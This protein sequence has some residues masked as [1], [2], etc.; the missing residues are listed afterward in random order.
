MR[1]SERGVALIKR[2]EGIRDGDP[3]TANLDP[4]LCPAG[5]ATIGWGHVIVDPETGEQL[6]GEDGLAR[7]RLLFPDGITV[8]QAEALLLH[9]IE[10][11]EPGLESLLQ[12]EPTQ[13]EWDAMMSFAFNVGLDID[14][15][16]IPE[17]LGDSTLLKLFNAGDRLGAADQFLAWNKARVNGVL[18]ELEGLTRR[19]QEEREVFLS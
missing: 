4:Y 10:E 2:W 17:G 3:T 19:R 8:H 11:R 12:R 15:D 18:Q 7:A 14:E 16:Q 6:R 1:T 9:D 13:G 5:I